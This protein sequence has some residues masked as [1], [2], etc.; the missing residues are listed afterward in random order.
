MSKGS[1]T[2]LLVTA[3]VVPETAVR[4][5]AHWKVISE[6]VAETYG[7]AKVSVDT[8]IDDAMKL[9]DSLKAAIDHDAR[10]IR[11]TELTPLRPCEVVVGMDN[12]AGMVC[13]VYVGAAKVDANGRV[14]LPLRKGMEGVRFLRFTHFDG[15]R[16]SEQVDK[17]II[18]MEPRYQ[19]DK[20][21]SLVAYLEG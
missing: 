5:L 1:T 11:E 16:I 10:E 17:E 18:K 15:H 8:D 7:D 21:V 4:E 9:V 13:P 19:G 3:G 14:Y 2:N 6:E 20:Q 12:K